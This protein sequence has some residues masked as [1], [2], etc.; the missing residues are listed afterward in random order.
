MSSDELNTR[1]RILAATWQLME[2]ERG[3]GV[4]MSDIAKAAGISRQAVYLHFTSRAELMIATTHYVDEIKGLKERLKQFQAATSGVEMLAALVE[5]WGNYIPEI[6]GLAQALLRMRASDEAT[7]AAWNE[8][9]DAL[10]NVCREVIETLEQEG[11]LAA[12][13]SQDEAVELLWT[14]LS[15]HHWEQLTITRGWSTRQYITRMKK[16]L[17]RSFIAA[18]QTG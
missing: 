9:M 4:R 18:E 7:D 15:I 5:V 12:E 3:Q 6:Y 17:N 10:R 11:R 14:M 13:W 2:Q 8:R 1:T 16:L